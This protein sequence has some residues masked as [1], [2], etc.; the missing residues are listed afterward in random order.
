MAK[1][2]VT[3]TVAVDAARL[4]RR[5][6][7]LEAARQETLWE[8]PNFSHR[9]LHPEPGPLVSLDELADRGEVP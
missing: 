1:P 3:V 4:R 8:H 6:A 7:M 9:N 5:L 2:R